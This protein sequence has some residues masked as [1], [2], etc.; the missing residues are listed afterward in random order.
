MLCGRESQFRRFTVYNGDPII[1][2]IAVIPYENM[3]NNWNETDR[4]EY[5]KLMEKC[6]DVI[7]L[8]AKYHEKCYAERNQ[9]MVDH[10]SR[11]ICYYDGG[12]RSGTGQTVRM[13]EKQ[14]LEIINLYE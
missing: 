3:P 4:E 7:T 12:V 2:V 14:N 1:E 9:Y 10:S 13:A 11:L 5:Y 8:N 6:D